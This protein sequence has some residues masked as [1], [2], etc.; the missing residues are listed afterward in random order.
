V[1]DSNVFIHA[2]RGR[3]TSSELISA[4]LDRFGDLSRDDEIVTGSLRHFRGIHNLF[5]HE[6]S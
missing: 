1:I 4:I 6:Y 3:Q 5:V 2:E